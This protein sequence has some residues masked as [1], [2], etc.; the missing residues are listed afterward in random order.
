MIKKIPQTNNMGIVVYI[1]AILVDAAIAAVIYLKLIKLQFNRKVNLWKFIL[2]SW[3]T[4]FVILCIDDVVQLL[5]GYK[6]QVF[7]E[8]IALSAVL[9]IAPA[10]GEYLWFS[11]KTRKNDKDLHN[12]STHP[13]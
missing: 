4:W 2:I 9:A 7:W 8:G 6:D 11:K 13:Q 10:I 3:M 12:S 1:G 5:F